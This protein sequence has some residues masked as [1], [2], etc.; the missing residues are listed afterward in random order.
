VSAF[1][2]LLAAAG[3]VAAWVV[4]YTVT[5]GSLI[6]AIGYTRNRIRRRNPR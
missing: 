2:D 5:V 4:A 1:L 3:V 6:A